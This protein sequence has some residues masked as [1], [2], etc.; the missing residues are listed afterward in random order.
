ML[1]IIYC[2]DDPRVSQSIRLAHKD[3][4]LAYLEKHAQL[5]L[6]GG[7]MLAEDGKT[8]VGSTLILNVENLAQ[9]EAFSANEPFR[10]AGLYES[11]TITRMRRAQ[12]RPDLAPQTVE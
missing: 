2:R 5:I 7:A 8:R 10:C 3:A 9:A 11:V 1:Y 4:H 6:L 12:W